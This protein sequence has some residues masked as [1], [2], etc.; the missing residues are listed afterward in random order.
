[1]AK[2]ASLLVILFLVF[3]C[4]VASAQTVVEKTA[5]KPISAA[6]GQAMFKSYCS[7]CHGTAGRGNGPAAPALKKNPANLTELSARNGGKFPEMEVYNAIKGD[8]EM[9]A[10]GSKD[11]PVWGNLFSSISRGNE[12]EIQ[13]RISNLTDY[14]KSIQGR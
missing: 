4:T 8:S 5:V 2:F 13:L 1:M 9:A 14:V 7:P 10:H 6:S 3:A 11:M 12:G